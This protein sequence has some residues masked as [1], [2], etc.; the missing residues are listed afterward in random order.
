VRTLTNKL[1]YLIKLSLD[2]KIKTKW[3]VVINIVL[4]IIII[5][6]VNIDT[7][8][9][10]FGGDFNKATSIVVRDNTG[11]MYNNF[12]TGFSQSQSYLKDPEKIKIEQSTKSRDELIDKIDSDK[13]I[14]V[15]ID[16]DQA[17]FVKA[18]IISN[19]Y[20][21]NIL[22]QIIT[23]SI[24]SSK[25][26]L[27]MSKS[28]IDPGLLAAVNAPV[29]VDRNILDESKSE[30]EETMSFIMGI[31][32]PSF[33]LPFFMLIIFLVQMIGA[34]I[35]EEKTTRSMEII[36][37]NVSPKTH[38]ISK[39]LASNIFVFL[40]AFILFAVGFIG[41]F[42]RKMTAASSFSLGSDFDLSSIWNTISSSGIAARLVYVI[43][44]TILLMLLSFLAYSLIAGILASMT[45]SIEDY[46]QVQTPIILICVAG[47]YLSM[48]APTFEGSIFIRIVSYLPFISTLISPPLLLIGQIGLGDVAISFILLIGVIYLMLTYGMK[49]YKVGILNY[50]TSKLWQK[51]FKAIK[52]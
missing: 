42:I 20:I 38:F 40:Q 8:I 23:S 32:F 14:V 46:Q 34:E 3:F 44:I 28:N 52:D 43:P 41:L 48:L 29:K 25:A 45:T 21:D 13:N 10:A 7:I 9:T 1:K 51:M 6:L 36:I 49:I 24:N 37:A 30:Q 27:A 31:V 33:I 50:S 22:Y 47:Y 11:E 16:N 19:S 17:N 2:K 18:E 12:K 26:T 5:G 4:A 15:I 39:I 35:N